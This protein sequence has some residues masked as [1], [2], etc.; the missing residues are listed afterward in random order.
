MA[1]FILVNS[2][3]GIIENAL[4]L[5]PSNIYDGSEVT[6]PDG[7]YHIP[8]GYAVYQSDEARIGDTYTSGGE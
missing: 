1:R 7:R 8:D 2:S 5:D 4:E 3:S 6:L